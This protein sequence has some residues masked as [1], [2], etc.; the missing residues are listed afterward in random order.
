MHEQA[1]KLN[2]PHRLQG[3][4]NRI[5]KRQTFISG[6]SEVQQIR[7]YTKEREKYKLCNLEKYGCTE[8]CDA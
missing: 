6:G 4:L 1:S 5:F 8:F 7:K 3:N 2:F